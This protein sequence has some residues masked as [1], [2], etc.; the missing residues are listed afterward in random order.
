M[1]RRE[2]K[3][4][5]K[6]L[7]KVRNSTVLNREPSMKD[8]DCQASLKTYDVFSR[9]KT[10]LDLPREEQYNVVEARG[11]ESELPEGEKEQINQKPNEIDRS[12]TRSV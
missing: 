6:R 11:I 2:K 7:K 1:T 8:N 5:K 12:L 10:I 3:K 4:Q 9:R